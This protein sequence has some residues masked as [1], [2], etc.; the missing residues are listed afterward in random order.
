[1]LHG[2]ARLILTILDGAIQ[3]ARH[4]AD[5]DGALGSLQLAW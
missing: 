1:M 2:A 5:Y 4:A 3:F